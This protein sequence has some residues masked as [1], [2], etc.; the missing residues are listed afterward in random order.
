MLNTGT[1]QS[2]ARL[3]NGDN[4]DRDASTP[5]ASLVV[6]TRARGGAVP[7]GRGGE[8]DPL[9]PAGRRGGC[10]PNDGEV[11]VADVADFSF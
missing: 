10:W 11:D 8:S 9:E 5:L 1:R 4:R 3:H 6:V 2:P 7:S